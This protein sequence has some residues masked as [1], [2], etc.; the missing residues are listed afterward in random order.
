MP[1]HPALRYIALM[2]RILIVDDEEGVRSFLVEALAAVGHAVSEVG[3]GE[4][5]AELLARRSF[6]LLVTD[7]KM[8][9][10]DGLELLR[11]V[12]SE[13][14][15]LEVIVLTAHGTIESAV[16]AMKLGAFDYLTKP[17]SGPDE[18][19]LVVSRA[20]ERRGLRDA[21]QRHRLT[22]DEERFVAVDPHSLELVAMLRK[23]ART[24]ATVLLTGESGTGKEVAARFVH[25]ESRR[26]QGP[27]VAV[28]CA[29]LADTL[30]ESEL[31]GHE[32]GAFTGATSQHRGRFELAD[33]GTLFLDEVAELRPEL[34]VKLLRVLQERTFERVG[35]T[36]H[37]E[38]DVR[39]I[40]ATNRNLENAMA[41][42]RFREDLYHRLAVFPLRLPAL[43][44]RRADIVPLATHLL[45]RAA[46]EV[47]KAGVTLSPEAQRALEEH[48]WPGNVRELGNVLER[49]T[50]L[51]EGELIEPRDLLLGTPSVEAPGVSKF[52]TLEEIEREAIRAALA[53]TGGHR[54]RT[55]E[56]LGIG[57][58]TLYDKLKAYRLE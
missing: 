22:H 31:F 13:Q 21:A 27:F 39:L 6:H 54:K 26:A 12:R 53:A 9:R 14:P 2:A 40:A 15:E 16:A 38:V 51:A 17:L 29:A 44:E 36:R 23:V 43:R 11:R 7:L 37:I 3:D 18:L 4:A 32:K 35:G 33:G 57:L 48:R 8:P 30:L 46:R 10:Q 55:A 45:G 5:A 19:R 56:R 49:A 28:N 1:S 52:A 34:Q 47:G 42:G 20:L 25:R 24:D 50:I 58:R 41:Q